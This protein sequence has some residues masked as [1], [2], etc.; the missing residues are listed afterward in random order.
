MA[1]YEVYAPDSAALEQTLDTLDMTQSDGRRGPVRYVV[2]NYGI[3]HIWD[4]TTA[5]SP[6]GGYEVRRLVAQAG[7]YA[8]VRWVPASMIGSPFPPNNLDFPEGVMFTT[9]IPSDSPIV[10]A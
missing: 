10:F 3:K 9:P 7:V 8:I 4:G 5:I 1:D 2:N 6:I